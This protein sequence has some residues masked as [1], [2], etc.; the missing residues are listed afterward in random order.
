[1][2]IHTAGRLVGHIYVHKDEH[3]LS[4]IASDFFT[5]LAGSLFGSDPGARYPRSLGGVLGY[6][7]CRAR[8]MSSTCTLLFHLAGKHPQV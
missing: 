1:M 3:A 5:L 2:P 4:P 7:N 6:P 8:L